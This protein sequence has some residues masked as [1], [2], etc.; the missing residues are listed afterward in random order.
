[1]AEFISDELGFSE[2]DVLRQRIAYLEKEN[3]ELKSRLEDK[4]VNRKAFGRRIR[5]YKDAF[6]KRSGGVIAFG[7]IYKAL[8]PLFEK[9]GD[10]VLLPAFNE[11]LSRTPVGMLSVEY[12]ARTLNAWRANQPVVQEAQDMYSD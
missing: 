12:F 3:A 4:S 11:Y 10:D 2:I 5:Q 1:M 7:R 8:S 6:E 9:Y